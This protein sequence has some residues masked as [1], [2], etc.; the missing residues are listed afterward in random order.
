MSQEYIEIKGARVNNLKNIDV[1]IPRNKF[2]VISGVSGSGKSSLAFDTLYAEGQRRYVESLSSYAR[3]FLGRMNKPECDFIRGIPPAIAIEQKV[4]ARN[5]RSTVGT[6]TEIYEYLRLLFARIGRTYSPISGEEVKKHSTEDVVQKMLEFSEGTKFV[7]MAP[8]KVPEGRTLEQQL[9]ACILQGYSRMTSP[10][11]PDGE[12]F[13]RID[14]YLESNP[15][16]EP[17][18]MPYLVIDRLSSSD[19]K[20]TI[21]RL[22]DSA[23]TAFFEGHGEMRLMVLPS[24]LSYDFSTRFEADGITFEEPTD[25]LFSFNSPAG[26]CPECQGFGKVMGIDEHLV[27]PDTGLSVY[28]GCVV[29]WHGEKMGEWKNW[30]IRH[31]ANDDFPIFEPYYNLTQQQKDWL[32]HGLPS[33]RG[34]KEKPCIDAFFQMVK[35]NQY[36]IQYRVMLARYRG[37]TTCPTCHGTRLKPEAEYVKINGRS[38][39]DLVQMPVIRLKDWFAQLQLPEH[40][41]EVGKRLLLEITSRLQF[42]LDVGLGYLTLNRLSNSLSGGESQRINLC[43]SLGSSL[44]GSLY[45]LDEPSI[46]LHSR[47]TDRLIHVLKELQALGNTVVVVEHDEE[48]IRAADYIIDIGPDAGRLGG[49]VVYA[50]EPSNPSE[51]S[52]ISKSSPSRSYT[53]QYLSGEET[54]PVPAS[55]R[56]WNRHID[57]KGARMNNLRGINVEIPLNV[58]TVVTGVSGSGKSSLIKGI[59]YPALKRH[60]GDVCDAPGEYSGLAGDLDA[61]RRVE[62]VDQNPIGKSSRSNPATYVKAYDAIRDLYA[63]QPL[64]QQ[65]GFT[66]QYFSFNADGGRCDECKGAGTITVEMQ[67][68]ADLVLECE[69]CHGKRFKHDILDVKYE[70]KNIDDILNMTITEAIEF[71]KANGQKTIVNRLKPLEDV[72][73][74]YIKLGQNSSTLSGGENQRVKLAYFIGQEKQEPTLFIFDEP[75]TGL[76]FHDIKR[77]MSSL[78]A[79]I[80]RGHTVLIIEHNMDVIKLADHVIDLGP[81][82]GDKGGNLVIAGTPEEVAK[83]KNSITGQYLKLKI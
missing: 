16:S 4:I 23:E 19:N 7:V 22:V 74:G 48:I 61:I 66:P 36:K 47:D 57:I 79:L 25:Q 11:T 30:F 31:A 5:P 40:D 65:M 71:F 3:Q 53:L 45:I 70:G 63:D 55:R 10:G 58:L 77:L 51:T 83:C 54:I 17:A 52:Q 76:H 56:P 69:A 59:L 41:A 49:E 26:A 8:V 18:E 27:I 60:M 6:S 33:D 72:G 78:D 24:G 14:D 80:A 68:M 50:G 28:D 9:K 29:C 37:K 2:V 44:V 20:E 64:S 82:G 15:E 75:T 35:E 43:T 21:S 1:R 32:W 67:F 42:L 46:G 81:D 62:F 12:Q 38:I 39:T 73:L 34:A 13:I